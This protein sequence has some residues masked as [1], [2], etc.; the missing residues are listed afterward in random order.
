MEMSWDWC[1][2]SEAKRRENGVKNS[3][4]GEQKGATFVM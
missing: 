4:R 1:T 3:G 2:F